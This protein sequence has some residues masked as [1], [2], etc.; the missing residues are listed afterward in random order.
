MNRIKEK[1]KAVI[2]DMDG[3][4]IKT[5]HIWKDIIQ[6]F[7]RSKGINQLNENQINLLKQNSSAGLYKTI[8]IFKKELNLKGSIEDLLIQKTEFIKNYFTNKKVDFVEGFTAFHKRLQEKGIASGL[9]TNATIETCD[10]LNKKIKLNNFFGKNIYTMEHV[11]NKAKPDPAIF[12]YTA[13]KLNVNP[14][15]C[16]IFEDSHVG[17]Q[18]AKNAGI[19]CIAVKNE[20]N[21]DIISNV[22]GYIEHYDQ[23]EQELEK[24]LYK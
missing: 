1:I 16:I 5:E 19:K 8:S 15:Q 17:F 24:I 3:T 12:L 18:A 2:F 14:D 20:F 22:H 4:I 10:I 21:E 7:L 6:S 9:A 11:N 13:K 23:A